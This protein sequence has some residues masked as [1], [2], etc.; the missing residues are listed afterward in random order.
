[1]CGRGKF[2]IAKW[3]FSNFGHIAL[4]SLFIRCLFDSKGV[5]G[6][7]GDLVDDLTGKFCPD[8]ASA[9]KFLGKKARPTGENI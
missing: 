2:V 5:G 3:A 8:M 1:M 7:N 9:E 6:C 4:T